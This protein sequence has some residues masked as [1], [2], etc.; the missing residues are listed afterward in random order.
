MRLLNAKKIFWLGMIVPL[1]LLSIAAHPALAG[2]ADLSAERAVLASLER[3]KATYEQGLNRYALRYSIRP[4]LVEAQTQL[5]LLERRGGCEQL[6]FAQMDSSFA[7]FDY[8][9]A[10]YDDHLVDEDFRARYG[11]PIVGESEPDHKAA[12]ERGKNKL[13]QAWERYQMVVRGE[14]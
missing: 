7:A 14:R 6:L 3:V 5:S 9:A 10:S 2:S 11:R 8:A 13:E 1:L 4:A 12:I